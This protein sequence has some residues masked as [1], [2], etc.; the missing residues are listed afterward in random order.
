MLG[1]NSDFLL[2]IEDLT[3]SFD[4]FKAVDDV[5]ITRGDIVDNYQAFKFN[6]TGDVDLYEKLLGEGFAVISDE[7]ANLDQIFVDT[8][9]EFG[10][11][12]DKMFV[13]TV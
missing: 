2:S 6:S 3:V 4:G 13:G 1:N 12:T 9:F 7:L 11:V 5:N 10:Y 8:K